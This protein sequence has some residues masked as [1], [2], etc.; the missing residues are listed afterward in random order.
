MAPATSL[1]STQTD[2]ITLIAAAAAL[3]ALL[4]VNLGQ[5]SF[6]DP[7]LWHEMALVREAIEQ[8]HI[9]L[10]DSFAYTPTVYP[11]VH[12]EWGAGAILYLVAQSFGAPGIMVL[13][14]LLI[15]TVAIC[16]FRT[17]R[18]RGTSYAVIISLTPAV[19]V[20]GCFGFTTI[21]A[22]VFT[23]CML[24]ILLNC[25]TADERGSRRWIW[26]WLPLYVAW[27]NIHAGFVVGA[28]LFFLYTVEQLLRGRPALH[29][30]LVGMMMAALVGVNPYG[31]SYV[32][33]LARALFMPR[34]M[35]S[36]WQSLWSTSASMFGI[37]LLSLSIAVYAWWQ[38]GSRQMSGILVLAAT[39]Y[40]A[41]MHTRHLSLYFVVWLCYV[42]AW[43]QATC[44]GAALDV[45]WRRHRG[46]IIAFSSLIAL[47]SLVRV[48]PAAPWK[49]QMPVSMEQA[50]TGLPIY[51]VGAVEYLHAA[52]F[53]GNLM[54]PFD[55]GGYV[56]WRLHPQVKISLDGRYEVAYRPGVVEEL[57]GFYRAEPGW[58][59][60]LA[61][62][63]TDAVL[64]PRWCPV[65]EQMPTLDGWQRVYR[66]GAFEIFAPAGSDLPR[67]D[68]A[69][70]ITAGVFP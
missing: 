6:V 68:R 17:A 43:L 12:H 13:K 64:V 38:L 26:L 1:P 5:L 45:V 25:L 56:M 65:V 52:G 8:G 21:R 41:A 67:V 10:A 31:W 20:A 61:H 19:L 54:V 57:E 11:V 30:I 40:A 47:V 16:C 53:Q 55:A 9:P 28:G 18:M 42:P 51:P 48:V 50:R 33:Y 22:Q 58:Q 29:L 36:E 62:Y 37:Y 15:A 69:D 39:A 35:T 66:D 60:V 32:P 27:L 24:A 70:A 3:V 23:M 4:L 34:P 59:E 49:L 46:A 44:L 7:D 14:F 63:P 2:R